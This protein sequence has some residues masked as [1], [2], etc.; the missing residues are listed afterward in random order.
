MV[1]HLIKDLF[2]AELRVLRMYK[3][4]SEDTRGQKEC[5]YLLNDDKRRI[6]FLDACLR[7]YKSKACTNE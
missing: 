6:D 4:R 7:V 2:N 1:Y 3:K 5:L